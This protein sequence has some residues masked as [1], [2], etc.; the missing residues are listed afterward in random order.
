M[1]ADAPSATKDVGREAAGDGRDDSEGRLAEGVV[2]AVSDLHSRV[3]REPLLEAD[4]SACPSASPRSHSVDAEGCARCQQSHSEFATYSSC[5]DTPKRMPN[6]SGQRCVAR[7]HAHPERPAAEDLA[8][9]A[10][11]EHLDILGPRQS[12]DRKRL[13]L[14]AEEV[15]ATS[16][17]RAVNGPTW[18]P[19][20]A[21]TA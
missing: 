8:D 9:G 5:V 10:L 7:R 6:L 19:A 3:G 17:T 15:A 13:L 18:L 2:G 21:R 1:R 4:R 12:L 11:A 14:G 20:L 16:A